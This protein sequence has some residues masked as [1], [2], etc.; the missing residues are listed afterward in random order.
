MISYS[1]CDIRIKIRGPLTL[2]PNPLGRLVEDG[3]RTRHGKVS[4]VCNLL[5]DE[6][7][8]V[9]SSAWGVESLLQLAKYNHDCI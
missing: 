6:P 7:D 5:P 4:R 9:A 1:L 8:E 2:A 3:W